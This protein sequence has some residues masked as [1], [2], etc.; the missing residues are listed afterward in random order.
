MSNKAYPSQTQDRYIVRFPDGM[1]D[2]IQEEAKANNRS[3]NAEIVARLER[4]FEPVLQ[5]DEPLRLRMA[6]AGHR[7][8]TMST[9]EIMLRSKERLLDLMESKVE[10]D[11]LTERRGKPET[12]RARL[13]KV[14]GLLRIYQE[15]LELTTE[16]LTEIAMAD[17]DQQPLDEKE[18]RK[19][20]IDRQIHVGVAD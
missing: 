6:L 1:R 17:V 12:V 3:M 15:Q 4:S 16:L 10:I 14:S 13:E 5:H 11:P 8:V 18:I 7:E 20:I 19:R 9:M 2:K